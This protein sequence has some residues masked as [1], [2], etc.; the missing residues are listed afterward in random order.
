[1][2]QSRKQFPANTFNKLENNEDLN[3]FC[4]NIREQYRKQ[5]KAVGVFN[6]TINKPRARE[7]R[8]KQQL[9]SSMT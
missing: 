5:G 6:T 7:F 8:T 4:K 2:K 3:R 9:I 1:M